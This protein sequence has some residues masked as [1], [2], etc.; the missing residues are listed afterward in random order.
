[1]VSFDMESLFADVPIA[2]TGEATRRKLE[3]EPSLADHM[4]LTPA[5][6]ADLLTFV[7]RSTYFQYNGSIY[8]WRVQPWGALVSAVIAN[9]YM[10]VFEGQEIE[11]TTQKPQ[12][13]EALRWWYLHHPGSKLCRLFLTPPQ[14]S[15]AYHPIHHGNKIAFLD[16]S[17]TTS[18]PLHT[19]TGHPRSIQ[20]RH[21]T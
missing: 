7:L 1:M 9:L 11:S 16:L 10:E 21:D 3:S 14:Q 8:S 12:D 4:T 5:Q 15:A 20:V 2:G 13:L 18:S 17:V 6:I 19:T